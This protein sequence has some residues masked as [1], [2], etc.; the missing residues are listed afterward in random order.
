MTET[1]SLRIDKWLWHARF[2]KSR[3]RATRACV[4]GRI[5]LNRAVVEKPHQPV[6]PGDVLTFALGPNI[7]VV[8]ILAL[9]TRRGPAAEARALYDELAPERRGGG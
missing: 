2:Y 4:E 6:R 8:K 3:A 1:A 7:R 5:R 9:G